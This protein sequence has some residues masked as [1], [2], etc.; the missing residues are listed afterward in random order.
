M[1]SARPVV[2]PK[3]YCLRFFSLWFCQMF[4]WQLEILRLEDVASISLIILNIDIFFFSP[5]QIGN[6]RHLRCSQGTNVKLITRDKSQ[7]MPSV[8][9][10][11]NPWTQN[12]R[13][14]SFWLG[15]W[16][17]KVLSPFSSSTTSWLGSPTWFIDFLYVCLIT[18][19]IIT[20]M[21]LNSGVP[22]EE[23]VSEHTDKV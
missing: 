11:S 13:G 7:K 4:H 14:P 15:L 22:C 16:N 10:W 17:Q 5:L 8:G 9:Q 19:N 6:F 3:K 20:I 12:H 2:L 23:S 18:Y 21:L 1:G